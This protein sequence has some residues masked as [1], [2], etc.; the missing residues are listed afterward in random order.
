LITF[1]SIFTIKRPKGA[2]AVRAR[3]EDT[4]QMYS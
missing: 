2:I 4:E 1:V 3:G